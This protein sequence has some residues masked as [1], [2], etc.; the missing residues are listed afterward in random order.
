MCDPTR[1]IDSDA[2]LVELLNLNYDTYLVPFGLA[3]ADLVLNANMVA[4]DKGW[5]VAGVFRPT[6]GTA[7][8]DFVGLP[9]DRLGYLARWGAVGRS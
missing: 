4:Y 9:L 1:S 3:V 2:I 8:V 5:E 6:F 7:C